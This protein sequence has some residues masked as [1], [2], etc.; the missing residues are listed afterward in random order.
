MLGFRA[1]YVVVLGITVI[2]FSLVSRATAGDWQL[3][4][5]PPG[6]ADNPP[7]YDRWERYD[8]DGFTSLNDCRE[9]MYDEAENALAV[10]FMSE[11]KDP[12][13]AK[14]AENMYMQ[15]DAGICFNAVTREIQPAGTLAH[16]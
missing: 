7:S 6:T 5:P 2:S 16:Q 12:A 11:Q 1:M 13:L 10:E 4:I 3:W 15:L 9:F 14:A 8:D